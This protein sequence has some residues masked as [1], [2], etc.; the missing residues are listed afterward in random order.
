M[1][2][3]DD[4]DDKSPDDAPSMDP[5]TWLQLK[6]QPDSDQAGDTPDAEASFNPQTWFKP[7]AA[8][9]A[10]KEKPPAGP[11]RRLLLGGGAAA[12]LGVGGLWLAT[13][14]KAP[15]APVRT[16]PVARAD[17]AVP[18]TER[19]Q[20]VRGLSEVTTALR[21]AGVPAVDIDSAAGLLAPVVGSG[22]TDMRLSFAVSTQGAPALVALV[23]RRTDGSG[24]RLRRAAGALV[25]EPLAS[26]LKRQ[27]RVIP[28]EMDDR[29][30]YSSAV[31][32]G[33]DDSLVEE[34]A[35]IFSYDFNFSHEIDRGDRF[36]AGI[37]QTV[38]D[39]AET[40]GVGRLVYAS[41]N[42]AKNSKAFY[43]FQPPGETEASWFSRDGRSAVRNLMRSPLAVAR[44]TSLFGMR[45]H[46][47]L[48]GV[49]RQ[50]KGVDFGCPEGTP[51][52]ASADGVIAFA[53]PH[54]G[55]G[56]Y[57]KIRHGET[58]ETAYAH[59]SGW[60]AGTV[61]GTPVRQGQVV[62]F[63]GN[64]GTSSGPHLHYEVWVEG[65]AADPLTYVS[66]E[67]RSLT[68]EVLTRFTAYM[69]E[70]DRLRRNVV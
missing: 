9:V 67:T 21:S 52:F 6:P 31:S 38:N 20:R 53:G 45:K 42:T 47:V 39:A 8:P 29:S 34:F 36:E 27:I 41:L 57:V 17:A 7:G 62:A 64:T 11:D 26:A 30:F 19:A 54:G 13:S 66:K 22:A 32:Q 49:V 63:S 61:V 4:R 65:Q 58:L 48:D 51:V 28:G 23:L 1:S 5:R 2:G 40:I 44:V 14:R 70:I 60:P 24:A 69:D 37:E 16:A 3:G 15:A 12:L 59:L 68:G 46:P 18:V 33:L 50:H 25:L 10:A 56:N 35:S 43:R 55:H